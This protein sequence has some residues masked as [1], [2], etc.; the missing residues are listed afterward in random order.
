M[1]SIDDQYTSIW[2]SFNQAGQII[3][4]TQTY[5]AIY[6]TQHIAGG[7][8]I[9]LQRTFWEVLA[10]DV[11]VGGGLRSSA[12]DMKS[13]SENRS[14]YTSVTEPGFSGIFPRI[15]AKLAIVL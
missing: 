5:G 15:G 1:Y 6:D 13:N 11:F 12:I 3:T 10:V 7:F 14:F 2:T 9:G 8:T 4:Q